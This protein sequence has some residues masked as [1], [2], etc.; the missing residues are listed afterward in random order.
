MRYLLTISFLLL[1]SSFGM[2]AQNQDDATEFNTCPYTD[3][4]FYQNIV[5][6]YEYPE[7]RLV[8]IDVETGNVSHMIEENLELV[9]WG[10]MEWSPDC[11]YVV[12]LI[13]RYAGMRLWD[14][15]EGRF[16]QSFSYR[17]DSWPY[18]RGA[19]VA[20]SPD[21]QQALFRTQN[22]F[23]IWRALNNSTTLLTYPAGIEYYYRSPNLNTVY[24]DYA[25]NQI[26]TSGNPGAIAFDMSSGAERFV[27]NPVYLTQELSR[28]EQFYSLDST[29]EVSH[30]GKL[31]IVFTDPTSSDRSRDARL[32]VW[33]L[34]T[35]E[36][37]DLNV[38]GAPGSWDRI[39]LSPDNRYLVIGYEY[40]RVWDL[41]NLAESYEERRPVYYFDGPEAFIWRVEMLESD[42]IET[43]SDDGIQRWDLH[44][45]ELLD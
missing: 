44:T 25:R 6:R 8:A 34:N 35:N 21:N 19:K 15:V 37:I 3:A 9:E 40:L 29:I 27:Y 43:Y 5:L 41:H 45:G 7:Q 31:L 4:E 10:V 26:I 33:D 2:Q 36:G 16:L 38:V 23:F 1:L 22:G 24:W 11:R 20:W 18:E 14:V 28:D 32:A 17:R 13:N 12:G 42:V 39:A 30:D